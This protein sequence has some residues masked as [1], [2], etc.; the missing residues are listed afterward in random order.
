[1]ESEP[2]VYLMV[3]LVHRYWPCAVVATGEVLHVPVGADV[4][5]VPTWYSTVVDEIPL[6]VGPVPPVEPCAATE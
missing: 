6:P 4:P 5:D 2:E 3:V 1:M